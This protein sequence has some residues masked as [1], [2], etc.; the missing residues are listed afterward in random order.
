MGSGGSLGSLTDF[1]SGES[2]MLIRLGHGFQ[3]AK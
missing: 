2:T 1:F 3:P